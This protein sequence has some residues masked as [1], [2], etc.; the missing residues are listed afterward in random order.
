MGTRFQRNTDTFTSTFMQKID[1]DLMCGI[2]WEFFKRPRLLPCSHNFCH[3]CIQDLVNNPNSFDAISI[4]PSKS[5]NC[6]FC[7]KSV[8]LQHGGFN[9]LPVNIA[10]ESIVE[11]YKG[12]S[13]VGIFD[14]PVYND[15]EVT[16]STCATHKLKEDMFCNSCNV[17]VCAECV[18]QRHSGERAKHIVESLKQYVRT[19]QVGTCRC[20]AWAEH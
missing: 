3:G 7:S 13:P 11:L 10:L 15:I 6:P 2:C 20:N 4:A 5:F 19:N 1:K 18:R 9:H 12:C 14:S 16:P 17:I 8:S